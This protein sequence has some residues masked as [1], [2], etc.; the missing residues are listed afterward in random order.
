MVAF[1]PT[2]AVKTPI[3][4]V[5]DYLVNYE[6]SNHRTDSN[7]DIPK[8]LFISLKGL[9]SNLQSN[10]INMSVDDAKLI[11]A[12]THNEID[13]LK[14]LSINIQNEQTN[15]YNTAER[16]IKFLIKDLQEILLNVI[17]EIEAISKYEIAAEDDEKYN[18]FLSNLM[19]NALNDPEN[20][21]TYGSSKLFALLDE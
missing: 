3:S 16:E 11:L 19:S 8:S 15:V 17:I 1:S 21:I 5:E 10:L 2:F 12:E 4:S 14:S 7:Y 6:V 9:V 18:F 20:K 13:R